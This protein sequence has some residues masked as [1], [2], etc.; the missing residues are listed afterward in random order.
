LCDEIPGHWRRDVAHD[1]RIDEPT[2]EALRRA[3]AAGHRPILVTGPELIDLFNTLPTSTS[4]IAWLR[5]T[6]QYVFDPACTAIDLLAPLPPAPLVDRLTREGVPL[7]IGRRAW[8]RRDG[9]H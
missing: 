4:S 1:G 7:S 5:K 6:A 2:L 8:R 9:A 3:R